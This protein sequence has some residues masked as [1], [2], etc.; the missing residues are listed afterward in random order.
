MVQYKKNLGQNFLIDLNK[1][2][3]IINNIPNLDLKGEIFL[4]VGPGKGAL[5]KEITKRNFVIAIEIDKK[6]TDY[7]KEEI[8]ENICLLNLDFLD[9]NLKKLLKKFEKVNF[10]SNL[11]YY[12]ST[13]IIFKIL[14]EEKI[15]NVSVMLQKELV[16]RI[17]AKPKT[18]TYGRLSV[19][20]NTFFEIKKEIRVPKECF[21]PKPKI[22][23]SFI[24]LK[25]KDIKID[26]IKYLAFIKECFANKRKTLLNSLK[27]SNSIYLNKVKDF[28]ELNKINILTRAEEIS[29]NFYL[30]MWDYIK[31]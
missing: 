31:Q 22:D 26:K 29:V 7:L 10:V 6:L 27:N 3:E 21:Y 2:N 1:I 16:E 9:V 14:E 8:K 28:L 13:K 30:L 12:I 18:K 23:S 19:S 15:Q 5:T 25:K 17:L 11:P 4:E 20:I 24:I